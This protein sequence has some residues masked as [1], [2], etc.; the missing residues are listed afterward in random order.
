MEEALGLQKP[1]EGF[2]GGGCD[3]CGS[4][5]GEFSLAVGTAGVVAEGFRSLAARLEVREGPPLGGGGLGA[6]AA[7]GDPPFLLTHF[8]SF[9]S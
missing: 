2:I 8:L 4:T 5:G 7:W 1:I 6:S 9:S 3:A